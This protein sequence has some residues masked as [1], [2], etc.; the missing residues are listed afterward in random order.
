MF[1][2]IFQH[3]TRRIFTGTRGKKSHFG[4]SF[5][6]SVEYRGLRR[7]KGQPPAHLL[8]RL[9]MADPA[10]G[11]TLPN[12]QWLPLLC[13]IR[14]GACALSY[15]ILSNG[16]VKILY[17]KE[18][19]AWDDFPY[20]GYPKQLPVEPMSLKTVKYDLDKP[21]DAYIIAASFGINL[22]TDTQFAGLARYVAK[23]KLYP[24]PEWS[25][26][27]WDSAE[28]FLREE[29][30]WWPFVQG[31][32]SEDCLNP[33]CSDRGRRGAMRTFA[34]FEEEAEKVRSL[35]GPHCGSLQ[36]IYQICPKCSAVSVSNQCT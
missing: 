32:P 16:A 36:I 34:V 11:I 27:G 23:R 25:G 35:W 7:F 4:H 33:A 12:V 26:F 1:F 10:V 6:G 5:G 30:G 14:Y 17:Q 8:C 13:A 29:H 20:D 22:L 21:K 18:S 3:D 2:V 19:K 28:D 9:N 31:P 24:N 15:Q